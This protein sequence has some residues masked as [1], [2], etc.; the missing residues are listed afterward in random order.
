MKWVPG[1]PNR[2]LRPQLSI[3]ISLALVASIVAI[4]PA[5]AGHGNAELSGSNFEIDDDA[6]LKVDDD[7][8][9]AVDWGSLDHPNGPE[10][11]AT[12]VATGQNDNSY[13]GGTKEDTE[14]PNE[15]TGSIP[16]NKSDLL[17]F[18]VYIEPGDPGFL[19]MGWS[20]VS[21]PSGTTLMD[22]EFNQS[23][24]ACPQGP[25]VER[26]EGDLLIEYAIDQGGAQANISGRFWTGT[27]WGPSIDLDAPN[28]ACGGDPCAVGTINQSVIP[29]AESDGLGEK[30]ARTFGEAQID[31]DLLFNQTE[32]ECT[33]FGSAM[34][35]SRSSDAFTSQLKDFIAPVPIDLNNCAQVIIRKETIPDGASGSFDF[36]KTFD[37]DPSS[38]DTFSLSDGEDQD[39]G[40]TV[41][42][43]TGYV[44]SE[45]L[46]ELPP[47]FTLQGIDCSASSGVT[48]SVDDVAG[49]VTF[50]LD[51]AS[52]VLDCTFT[53][54]LQQGAIEITKT[55]KHAVAGSDS[56]PHGGVT[57]TVSGGSLTG[58][59]DVMTDDTGVA[60]LEGLLLSSVAGDYTVTETVP[61]GY[62]A[63]GDNP[64]MVSVTAVAECGDDNVDTVSFGNTPLTDVTISIDSLVD[65]GTS[66]TIACWDGADTSGDPDYPLLTTDPQPD[67]D[68]DGELTINDLLP[69]DPDV[70]LTCQITVD[71]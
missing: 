39:Y 28:D 63:D 17:T 54:E 16:N 57:F 11:R 44:V 53:N 9:P 40:K 61:S 36:D 50:D 52:D 46:V 15:T 70:T 47:G 68:G 7:A 3:V 48:P 25:N 45:D 26:T 37:T 18:H 56:D 30:Q 2:R 6:N 21:D 27:E 19:N 22:F 10:L 5:L 1:G 69:T 59:V 23:S 31:L 67:D 34:L 12:D 65:G 35:K 64:K 66:T 4:V 13:K 32:P 42:L 43:G 41:F 49:T 29:A 14:C 60:C 20:R 55:R 24:T 58:P 71:P 8:P 51:A 62:K 33:A 38:D